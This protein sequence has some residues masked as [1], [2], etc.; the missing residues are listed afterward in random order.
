[1]S[2]D[3]IFEKAKDIFEAAY[4]KTENV[5]VH[6]KQ[7]LDISSLESKL[8]KSYETLGKACFAMLVDDSDFDKESLKPITDDIKEKQQLIENAKRE[9]MKTQNKRKCK[10]CGELID[11]NSVF[12]KNCGQKVN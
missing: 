10:N 12:C 9:L 11:N 3:N 5:V 2:I 6:Q 7:K 4:R 8:N 1:M